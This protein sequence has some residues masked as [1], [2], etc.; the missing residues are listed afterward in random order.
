MCIRDREEDDQIDVSGYKI[1]GYYLI[2]ESWAERWGAAA[3]RYRGWAIKGQ[4][5]LLIFRHMV[6][7]SAV[8]IQA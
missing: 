3:W 7:V 8:C 2:E 1:C 4:L 6:L 5:A